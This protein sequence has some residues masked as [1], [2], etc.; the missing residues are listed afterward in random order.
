MDLSNREIATLFWFAALFGFAALKGVGGSF[1][2]LVRA[3]LAPKVVGPFLLMVAYTVLCAWLLSLV[4]LWTWA[5][6]KTTILWIGAFAFVAMFNAAQ[7]RPK[8]H[9]VRWIAAETLTV[10]AIVLFLADSFS[11]P[12]WAELALVPL[13]MIVA[14]MQ[15]I[16]DRNAKTAVLKTPLAFVMGLFTLLIVG[17]GLHGA[18]TDFHTFA[19]LHTPRQF[20]A[21]HLPSFFFLPFLL[22]FGAVVDYETALTS[23]SFRNI[24]RNC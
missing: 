5:N 20:A 4:Q 7:R 11:F 18:V 24:D 19:S 22:I 6:L 14:G 17:N 9:P 15:V 12:F 10:T 1:L 8:E 3:F 13:V 21:P 2:A 23:L 16:V